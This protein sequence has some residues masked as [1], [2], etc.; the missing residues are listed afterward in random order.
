MRLRPSFSFP[1]P[2]RLK[3]VPLPVLAGGCA[4]LVLALLA[5]FV[6]GREERALRMPLTL[7]ETEKSWTELYGTRPLDTTTWMVR[8]PFRH[9]DAP[10]A[11]PDELDEDPHN[12]VAFSD[13][14]VSLLTS[15]GPRSLRVQADPQDLFLLLRRGTHGLPLGQ[16][17]NNTAVIDG[18][19][20]PWCV[21][22]PGSEFQAASLRHAWLSRRVMP[23][24]EHVRTWV[25]R[26]KLDRDLVYAIMYTES[27]F[28]PQVISRRGA[29]GLMQIVPETAGGEVHK[30][31]FG[32]PG[33]PRPGELLNPAVNIQYGTAYLHLLLKRHLG[34]VDDPLTREYCAVAAYNTGPGA[35]LKLFGNSRE[36]AFAAIN[37]HT[38][39][40]VYALL[41]QRLPAEET[42]QFLRKVLSLKNG[43]S[44]AAR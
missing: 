32:R 7:A 3:R 1:L 30:Y 6:P 33:Q 5:G 24:G 22:T 44:L 16:S 19:A 35:V 29:H 39:A 26:F 15:E 13:G 9:T 8:L 40:Q 41:Q 42:R 37:G 21:P 20:M 36:E 38:P 43:L 23:Y 18:K 34:G 12:V 14:G 10:Q 25:E 2:E 17:L 4:A 27:G 31:L 11:F 28:N